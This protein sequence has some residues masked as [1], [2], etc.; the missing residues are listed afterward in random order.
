MFPR[1]M[2]LFPVYHLVRSLAEHHPC[3]CT[4]VHAESLET[5]RPSL[6]PN[7]D[8]LS[9]YL[10]EW[11]LIAIIGQPGERLWS[12]SPLATGRSKRGAKEGS[13]RDPGKFI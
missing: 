13:Y 5:S 8:G 2:F 11:S 12:D 7:Y 1:N 9:L 6:Y 10:T 3:E 4:P